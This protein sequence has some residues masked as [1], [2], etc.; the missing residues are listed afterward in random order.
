M[1]AARVVETAAVAE[2]EVKGAEEMV[3][4]RNGV[5]TEVR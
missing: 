5:V 1:V 3:E 2:A 4:A